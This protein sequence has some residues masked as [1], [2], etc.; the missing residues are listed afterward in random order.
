M[1]TSGPYATRLKLRASNDE[2]RI[3]HHRNGDGLNGRA[4]DTRIQICGQRRLDALLV[5]CRPN[6]ALR[7]NPFVGNRLKLFQHK[8]RVQA[9][10]PLPGPV[11]RGLGDA[12]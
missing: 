5:T 10:S 7:F 2:K 8:T 11:H 12:P 9:S 6:V 1:P 3:A 4:A